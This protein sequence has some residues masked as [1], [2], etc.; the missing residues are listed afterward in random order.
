MTV[1]WHVDDSL[2]ERYAV[3]GLD[4]VAEAAVEAHVMRCLVCRETAQGHVEP[5]ADL[6]EAVHL[7]ISR[8][9][10]RLV[11][12][13]SR[14]GLEASDVT[15]LA[16]GRDLVLSAAVA[17]GAATGCAILVGLLDLR[18]LLTADLAF[19]LVAPLVPM[20]AVVATYDSTDPLRELTT[21]TPYSLIRLGLLRSTAALA[22][23]LPVT[24]AVAAALPGVAIGAAG[25]LLPSLLLSVIGLLALTWGT[26]RTAA[27]LTGTGWVAAA[28]VAAWNGVLG[29]IV[30]GP[31]QVVCAVA[32]LLAVAALAGRMTA[33]TTPP[34][35]LR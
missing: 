21:T 4:P 15:V 2:W 3:G 18:E 14:V 34:G 24:A 22:A 1:T 11:D 20:L 31:A 27:L 30:T 16:T 28:A 19:L 25:W 26:A 9:R 6:W 13:L 33:L 17:L 23:A 29:E 5:S 35:V 7:E 32:L 10:S 12:A 8:P